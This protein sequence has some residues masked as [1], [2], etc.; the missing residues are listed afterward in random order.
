[1]LFK[2]T[3][4]A[5]LVG[6][7]SA[8]TLRPNN[9]IPADSK[10]GHKLMSKARVLDEDEEADFTWMAG[11][12]IK[13]LGCTSIVQVRE[14]GGEEDESNLYTMNL[15]KFTLCDSS[16]SCNKCKGSA[17]EYVVNMNDFVDAYTETKM[18]AQ[19][20][21]CEY[22]RESCDCENAND[23]EYCEYQCYTNLGMD[24]CIQVDGDEEFNAQEYLECKGT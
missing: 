17:A 3:I 10:A 9:G 7:A 23:D 13:Y 4:L 8:K 22:A 5:L 2:S 16:V 21:A 15:V 6:A 14:E 24:Y 1:M 11:Y 12:S 20:Q 19:E 18:N